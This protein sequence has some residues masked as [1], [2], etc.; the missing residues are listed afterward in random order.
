MVGYQKYLFGNDRRAVALLREVIF[1][2]NFVSRLGTAAW[3]CLVLLWTEKFLNFCRK[4]L[5]IHSTTRRA[6][7]SDG[8]K[9]FVL[10]LNRYGCVLL[11][12]YH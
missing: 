10:Y 8:P 11:L 12:F 6:G 5:S 2:N 9:R 7:W 3:I 1:L 4:E